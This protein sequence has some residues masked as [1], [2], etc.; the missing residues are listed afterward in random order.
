MPIAMDVSEPILRA[1]GA[2]LL[3]D[4]AVPLLDRL[5]R[6]VKSVSIGGAGFLWLKL[7]LPGLFLRL[8]ELDSACL[9][10]QGQNPPGPPHPPTLV[11]PLP[12][13][14]PAAAT[15]VAAGGGG[16]SGS[17]E[18]EATLVPSPESVGDPAMSS[19]SRDLIW[20]N[21]SRRFLRS[22]FSR[23]RCKF[24]CDSRS[25]VARRCFSSSSLAA[26]TAASSSSSS[27][28]FWARRSRKA[29]WAARFC[30]FRFCEAR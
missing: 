18:P 6:K 27:L 11:A 23:S 7:G 30:A 24:L 29:R 17:T 16:D 22:A 5:K 19:S 20:F 28:T 12:P 1:G 3:V 10:L 8:T 13:H 9:S 26:R 2:R 21:S 14:P 4:E 25:I 15:L